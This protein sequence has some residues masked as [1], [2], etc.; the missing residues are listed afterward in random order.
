MDDIQ[1]GTRPDPDP[2]SRFD[3]LAARLRNNGSLLL[4]PPF[5]MVPALSKEIGAEIPKYGFDLEARGGVAP[6]VVD[7]GRR[8]TL[9]PNAGMKE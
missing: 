6:E 4:A 5:K 7:L 9:S 1:I 8:R 2:N 3:T